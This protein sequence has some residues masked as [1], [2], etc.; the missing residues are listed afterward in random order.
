[1]WEG[2]YGQYSYEDAVTEFGP[3]DSK[4]TLSSGVTVAV[5]KKR[6]TVGSGG[7][8]ATR[9]FDGSYHI[10]DNP[11]RNYTVSTILSF[12]KAGKLQSWKER[13]E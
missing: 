12:D 8:T 4:E 10:D 1:M 6:I 9:K 3:A 2:R 5:W 7:A 11:R 13:A